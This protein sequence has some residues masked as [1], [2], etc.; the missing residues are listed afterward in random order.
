MSSTSG[1]TH[2]SDTALLVAAARALESDDPAGS[3]KDPYAARLAGERGMALFRQ[4]PNGERMRCG[5]GVRTRFID[6]LVLE[7][8][9]S[10]QLATVVNLGAGLDTR[11]WRLDLPEDL[12]WI[13][14]DFADVLDFKDAR[15]SRETPRCRR[16]RLVADLTDASQRHA[17]YRAIGAAPALMITEGLL[18][19]LPFA[20]VDA[21]ASEPWRESGV[22]HWIAEVITAAF[23]TAVGVDAPASI[24]NVRAPDSVQGE[25][26]IEAVRRHGWKTRSRRSFLTDMGFAME[27]LVGLIGARARQL[28]SDGMT[29]PSGV[30]RFGRG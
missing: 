12:H 18:T 30:H 28:P 8:I 25:G 29:D 13:E 22:A 9:A 24:R 19:Y 6:E 11:P 7:A 20:V 27:R 5:L 4:H 23:S 26:V 14:V 17:V 10:E 3:A 15:M 1:I 16:D 2:V 21:L